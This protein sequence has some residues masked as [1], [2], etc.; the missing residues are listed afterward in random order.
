M[1]SKVKHRTKIKNME[2]FIKFF[3]VRFK[4]KKN[5]SK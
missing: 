2:L 1:F 5:S 4:D 3:S